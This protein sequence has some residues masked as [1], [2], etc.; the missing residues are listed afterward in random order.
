MYKKLF[1]F[2]QPNIEKPRRSLNKKCMRVPVCW[3]PTS[4]SKV[5]NFIQETPHWRTIWLQRQF[6]GCKENPFKTGETILSRNRRA[7]DLFVTFGTWHGKN[8]HSCNILLRTMTMKMALL[9]RPILHSTQGRCM[10]KSVGFFFRRSVSVLYFYHV[11]CHYTTSL[12]Y[13]HIS[14]VT[15][16]L[17]SVSV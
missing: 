6:G 10:K 9:I 12:V 1:W 7:E 17:L 13:S 2:P 15:F 11:S 14:I 4:R 5:S 16:Y 8:S 3:Y